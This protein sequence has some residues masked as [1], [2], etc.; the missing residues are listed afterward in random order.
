M[1][2]YNF[3][4]E[5]RLGKQHGNV[6]GLSRQCYPCKFCSRQEDKEDVYLDQYVRATKTG[7]EPSTSNQEPVDS[8]LRPKSIKEIREA[9][10][11]DVELKPV[12]QWLETKNRPEWNGVS[13]LNRNVKSLWAKWSQL[14]DENGIL[15]RKYFDHELDNFTKELILPKLWRGNVLEML[16]NDTVSGHLGV[17]RTR[18]RLQSRVYWPGISKDIAL[19][20]QQ[21]LVCQSRKRPQRKARGDLG[22]YAVGIPMER[23]AMDLLGPYLN[24]DEGIDIYWLYQ[25][26]LLDG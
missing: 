16:H 12:I 20:C 22:Q 21:C 1:E 25:I 7:D 10:L 11:N 15:Y 3:T 17:N 23:V 2:S 14:I 5:H 8:W 6:D 18:A 4:I 19:W 13:N 26:I 24:R 9:Q